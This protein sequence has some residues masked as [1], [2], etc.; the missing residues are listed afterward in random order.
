MAKM[1]NLTASILISKLTLYFFLRTLYLI[2]SINSF[3]V[4]PFSSNQYLS[5]QLGADP[6]VFGYLQTTFAI[7]QLAG[8]P[9]FGR[10]GDLF[11]SRMAMTLAFLA[12]AA[13]YFLLYMSFSMTILFLSRLPSVFMHAM[14]GE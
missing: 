14:Q 6:V 5:K 9:L 11:G 1:F 2:S 7:V 4:D 12:A 3:S 10:F 13:S 8:G